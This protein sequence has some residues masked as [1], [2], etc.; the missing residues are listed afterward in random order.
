MT[1]GNVEEP[2]LC[3]CM[4][5]CVCVCVCMCACGKWKAAW[6]FSYMHACVPTGRQNSSELRAKRPGRHDVKLVVWRCSVQV[7]GGLICALPDVAEVLDCFCLVLLCCP[8]RSKGNL[9]I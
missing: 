9:R 5:A 6:M 2:C 1:V 7:A 8:W 3:V 4:Y